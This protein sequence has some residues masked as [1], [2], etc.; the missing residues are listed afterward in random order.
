MKRENINFQK[1]KLISNSRIRKEINKYTFVALTGK[2]LHFLPHSK[3]DFDTYLST[4]SRTYEKIKYKF[5][6]N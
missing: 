4:F 1:T 3:C 2:K 6:K 5:S